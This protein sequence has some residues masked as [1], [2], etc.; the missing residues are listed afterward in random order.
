LNDGEQRLGAERV[1]QTSSSVEGM[2][3]RFYM[4]SLRSYLNC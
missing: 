3:A 4:G 1:G 2:R